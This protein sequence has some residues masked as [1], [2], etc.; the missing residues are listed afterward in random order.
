MEN[1]GKRMVEEAQAAVPSV[2]ALETYK[3][4]Q[5]GERIVIL[6]VR[7]PDEWANGHIETA[8]LLARGRIEGRIEEI[9]PDKNVCI[10][11]H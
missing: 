3:R 6:D 7:E 1:I 10:V 2:P 11:A 9:I 8:T 5:S 4:L